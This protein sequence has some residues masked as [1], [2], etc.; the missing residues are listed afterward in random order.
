[1]KRE[2][3]ELFSMMTQPDLEIGVKGQINTVKRFTGQ[4]SDK[5]SH[6]QPIGQVRRAIVTPL[7]NMMAAI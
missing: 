1:M 7:F 4:T 3:E 6:S 2:I 5:F